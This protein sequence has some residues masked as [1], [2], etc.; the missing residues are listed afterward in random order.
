M[1]HN[2]ASIVRLLYGERHGEEKTAPLFSLAALLYYERPAIRHLRESPEFLAYEKPP[3]KRLKVTKCLFSNNSLT[4][5]LP[6]G[7]GPSQRLFEN[8]ENAGCAPQ[9]P[10]HG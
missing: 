2:P 8:A 3:L 7:Q 1:S 6:S 5:A 10:V 9:K 4:S